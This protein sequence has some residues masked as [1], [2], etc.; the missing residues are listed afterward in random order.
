MRRELRLGSYGL[1][2]GCYALGV[3]ALL[4]GRF[5]AAALATATGIVINFIAAEGD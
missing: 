3:H 2:L 4:Q 5:G 1:V